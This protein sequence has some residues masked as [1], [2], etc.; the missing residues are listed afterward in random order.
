MTY[1]RSAVFLLHI[2][3]EIPLAIQGIWS[4]AALPFLELNNTTLVM[5]KVHSGYVAD[6]NDV[7]ADD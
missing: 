2:A 5:L 4:P 6:A 7:D 3:L 1:I